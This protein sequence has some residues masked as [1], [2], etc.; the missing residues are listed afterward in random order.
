MD[1]T[2][3]AKPILAIICIAIIAMMLIERGVDGQL[4]GMAIAFIAG[5][6]GLEVY[7]EYKKRSEAAA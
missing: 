5:L 2:L 6:G 7:T 4:I 3:I 1:K